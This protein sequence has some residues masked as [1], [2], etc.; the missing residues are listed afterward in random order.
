MT[1]IHGFELI[2]EQEIPEL[3]T[4]ARLFRHQKTSAEL[5]SLENDEENKVFGVAF[6]T[7][8]TDSTGLPHI[9]EH[10]V[11]GGSRKYPVKEP[12]V[13]LL[14]GSLQTFINAFTF[15]DKTVYPLASQNLRDF[16]NL[17]D[18][19][20][21]AVFYPNITAM[22]LQQEGWHYEL[23]TPDGPLTYKGVV[24]N[25]M[26]GAYSDPDNLMARLIEQSLFPDTTYGVDSGGD[27]A[28]IPDLTYEQFTAFHRRHYHPSNALFWFFGDDDPTERLRIVDAYL[29]DFDRLDVE[30]E[31]ALQPPF[32]ASKRLTFPF[33]A[34]ESGGKK[35][36]LA[37]NWVLA[38]GHNPELSLAL[39]ILTHIL[40][41][42]PAS[43]LRKALID[44]GLGEDLAGTGFDPDLRQI[45]FSTGL[46]G[47]ALA[48]SERVEAVILD[49][50][51][52]LVENGIDPA[53]IAASLNT[54]EFALREN[55]TG[56]FP[57]GVPL[58]IKALRT[59]LYGGDPLAPLAFEAPLNA[60]K[61]RLEAGE[62][63]FEQLLADHLLNNPHRTT[64]IMR[65]D[66][67]HQRRLEAAERERLAQ[68]RAA[69]S[70]DDVQRVLDE[71]RA[72]QELQEAPDTPEAL[73]T[74]PT[75]A[76]EDL[77][78]ASKLLPLETL[79]L[80]GCPVLYHDLFTNG[81]VYLDV[82]FDL[83]AVSQADL[84]YLGLFGRALLEMG[85]E[86]EDFVR[87]SQRIGRETGG[88]RATTLTSMHHTEGR[89]VAWG[90]LR[91]KAIAGQAGEMLDI[92]RDILLTVRLD[93][94][95]RFRQIVM[96]EKAIAEAS[97]IPHGHLVVRSRLQAHFNEA[98]W[99]AEQ[100]GGVS[101]L[102]FLRKLAEAIDSDWPGVLA[103]LESIRRRLVNRRSMLCNVT[104]DAGNWAGFRSQLA[105]FLEA[106]PAAEPA[107]SAW[108]P[109][110]EDAPEG[111][112]IPAQ[113]N[114]VAKGANLYELGYDLHGSILPILRYLGTTWIWERVRVRGGA[115]GG[116]CAF[117]QQSGSLAFLSY[118][119]PNLQATLDA[120]DGTARFLRQLELSDEELLKSIIGA[121]G[122]LDTYQ[123][124]DAKGY[125]S[126]A[127]HLADV[128]DELRQRIRDEVLSTTQADFKRL[129]D[130]LDQVSRAGMVVVLGSKN[131]IQ[132][133][134]TDGLGL[135]VTKVL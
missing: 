132:T 117:D 101:Y 80:S 40:I 54:I 125:T 18:V 102:F 67:D 7:P 15:S 100:I 62:R 83:R 68:A 27:P 78:R 114:Y 16:Y 59:W 93:N 22:T 81:I 129:A 112:T 131:A 60:L 3:N 72:L 115:Y 92:L 20:L 90:F 1:V 24:F 118:R 71:A 39:A 109:R 95:D 56:A 76:L 26:K 47:I 79:E 38:E 98:D 124:P 35:A 91:A 104:L 6:R 33:A 135:Q 10:A 77:D 97:L 13:E 57:R 46:K 107:L 128:T 66:P 30:A 69:M 32:D 116:F 52:T 74:I 121:I 110:L 105:G 42:T 8:P 75:L 2:E 25:E 53:M 133:A 111:L 44:S 126:M 94:R 4:R 48:D 119:D 64:V 82:G 63:V 88:I 134:N 12:F 103:R 50:L 127:R 37:M 106:L 17:I 31:I 99:A 29:S 49:T 9:L 23:E 120:Y 34:D 51:R 5:L 108:T 123:L 28:V 41:G 11:L 14:K 85:T 87:L 55:N 89:A 21:D 113:V 130:V 36:M 43:P 84:P 58:M 73:A 61:A 19:Y 86:R 70:E 45:V 65:P 96:E 122:R